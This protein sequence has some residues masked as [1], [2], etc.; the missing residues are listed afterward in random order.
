[1]AGAGITEENM[2]DVVKRTNTNE[3]HFSAK[4]KLENETLVSDVN[5]IRAIKEIAEK[6]FYRRA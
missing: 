2:A 1:M 4:V 5:K 3:F 6:T